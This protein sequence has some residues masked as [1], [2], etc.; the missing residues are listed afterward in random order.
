MPLFLLVCQFLQA[1]VYKDPVRP[2]WHTLDVETL[3][4]LHK[5][6]VQQI[7]FRE[8]TDGTD[9]HNIMGLIG[10]I[11]GF[12]E[13]NPI[14]TL[15]NAGVEAIEIIAVTPFSSKLLGILQVM[16]IDTEL[17]G[18]FRLNLKNLLKD[19]F[20][21][22][23]DL[24]IKPLERV[25]HALPNGCEVRLRCRRIV[26]DNGVVALHGAIKLFGIL[27][28][29]LGLLLCKTIESQNDGS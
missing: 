6:E 23:G 14:S 12:H 24:Q 11:V 27:N 20:L 21:I 10:K 25:A 2:L 8:A 9:S 4:L 28:G 19:D 22:H 29:K 16:D 7:A 3:V 17:F 5:L 13:G 18:V 1:L 26:H 15:D